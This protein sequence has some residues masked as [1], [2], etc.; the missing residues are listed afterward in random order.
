MT[1]RGVRAHL[2]PLYVFK[3]VIKWIKTLKKSRKKIAKE[4]ADKLGLEIMSV[5][6]VYEHGMRILRIIADKEFG[7]TIDDSERLN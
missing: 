1:N 5:N 2:T 3:M 4:A 6:L 7:L